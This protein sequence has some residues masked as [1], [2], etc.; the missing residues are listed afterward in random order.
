VQEIKKFFARIVRFTVLM[1]SNM[2]PEFYRK[3]TEL[4]WQQ[5][6]DK[7]CTNFNSVHEI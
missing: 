5:N 7:H 6:L 4:P 3:P 2:A 1:N